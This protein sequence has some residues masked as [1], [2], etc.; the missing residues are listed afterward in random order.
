ML[1]NYVQSMFMSP[2]KP[3][4]LLMLVLIVVSFYSFYFGDIIVQFFLGWICKMLRNDRVSE[5]KGVCWEN[6][7]KI[8]TEETTSKR[9]NVD[10]NFYS[11]EPPT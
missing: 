9:Q 3:S 6:C 11:P 2:H 10:G 8:T 7:F 4:E 1:R 5:Q